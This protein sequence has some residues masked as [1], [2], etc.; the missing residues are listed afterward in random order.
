[1]ENNDDKP[2]PD[3]FRYYYHAPLDPK[4]VQKARIAAA[5]RGWRVEKSRQRYQHYN[6]Q[7]GLML[8]GENDQP[9]DGWNYD[10]TPEDVLQILEGDRL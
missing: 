7:G 2:T 10:L 5:Q 1:L 9:I 8:I 6:N 4:M 3:L